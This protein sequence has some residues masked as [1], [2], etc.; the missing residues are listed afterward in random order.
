[1]TRQANDKKELTKEKVAE[2]KYSSSIEPLL[3][4]RDA[5]SPAADLN[6]ISFYVDLT[7][8]IMKL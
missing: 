5:K 1:M 4:R 7:V 3:T 6:V 8:F 2:I